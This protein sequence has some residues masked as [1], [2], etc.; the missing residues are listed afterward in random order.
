MVVRAQPELRADCSRCVGLCCVAPAFTRSADFAIDKPAGRP[1]PNLGAD[2]GCGIHERL[3]PQGFPGCAAYDCFGA[4]QTVTQRTFAGRDWRRHP[5]IA[6]SMFAAFAVMR[7]LHEL[8][9]YLAEAMALAPAEPVRDELSRAYCE[10]E[11]LTHA[12]AE[13]LVALDLAAH[14]DAVNEL[15]RRASTLARA[16]ARP[17][18]ADRRGAHIIGADLRGADLR[19][20]KLRG[21]RL[22][23]ADLRR[24]DLRVADLTGADLR[25]ADL[26]GAD[27]TG[28]LFLTQAQLDAATGDRD[29]RLPPTMSRPAHWTR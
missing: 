26:G 23:G 19:A 15:L 4:G 29:T 14:R 21:A 12:S 22:I 3:R 8:L 11:E 10:T 16:P 5:E 25:G 28:A 27:L 13:A 6:A 1:C 2:F 17:Q 24:A 20:A 18:P 7:Q 9:S